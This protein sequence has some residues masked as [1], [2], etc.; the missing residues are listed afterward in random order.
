MTNDLGEYRLFG[1]PPG[2]YYVSAQAEPPMHIRSPAYASVAP[3][4]TGAV[5]VSASGGMFSG[6]PDPALQRQGPRP[7]WSPV[8][9]G[10]TVDEFAAT[11]LLVRPGNDLT[12]IDIVVDRRATVSITGTATGLTGQPGGVAAV[13]ATP[14]AD[15]LFHAI[16]EMTVLGGIM[17]M[18][19][20]MPS[21]TAPTGEFRIQPT[22]PIPECGIA[23]LPRSGIERYYEDFWHA[24]SAQNHSKLR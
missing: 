13:V 2:V 11:P 6:V 20:A 5:V 1:L 22:P 7:D 12:G 15:P 19:P 23:G 9:Y 18:A 14:A 24:G 16:P 10:G 17:S 8:Y 3:V 21:R 4:A